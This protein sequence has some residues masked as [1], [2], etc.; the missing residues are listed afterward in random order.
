MKDGFNSRSSNLKDSQMKR[1]AIYFSIGGGLLIALVSFITAFGSLLFNS[2][3]YAESISSSLESYEAQAQKALESWIDLEENNKLLTADYQL[4][5]QEI[6]QKPFSLIIRSGINDSLLFYSG[7]SIFPFLFQYSRGEF[8]SKVVENSRGLFY[9]SGKALSSTRQGLLIIPLYRKYPIQN[10]FLKD[11]FELSSSI[12]SNLEIE[13]EPGLFPIYN[14][15]GEAIAYLKPGFYKADKTIQVIIFFI[16][17]AGIIFLLSGISSMLKTMSLTWHFTQVLGASVL[18]AFLTWFLFKISGTFTYFDF[19]SILQFNSDLAGKWTNS[20]LE[21]I[22]Q[23]ALVSWIGFMLLHFFYL[24]KFNIKVAS[25][26]LIVLLL[27]L[28]IA[29]FILLYTLIH[30]STWVWLIPL[31]VFRGAEL[32]WQTLFMYLALF[33][34]NTSIFGVTGSLVKIGSKN[35]V[36]PKSILTACF[37][38]LFLITILV[39][40]EIIEVDLYFTIIMSLVFT[41]F[42]QYT[43]GKGEF[44]LS[45]LVILLVI[46]SLLISILIQYHSNREEKSEITRFISHLDGVGEESLIEP[47]LAFKT[48]LE[49]DAF[50][51][52]LTGGV[53]MFSSRIRAE[54]RIKTI[55]ARD[56]NL[57]RNFKLEFEMFRADSISWNNPNNTIAKTLENIQLE[58][59]APLSSEIWSN[60]SFG[61]QEHISFFVKVATENRVNFIKIRLS[62][63]DI[64]ETRVYPLLL[65][66]TDGFQ[67]RI[68]LDY[69]VYQH[70]YKIQHLGLQWPFIFYPSGEE[71]DAGKANLDFFRPNLYQLKNGNILLLQKSENNWYHWFTQFLILFFF[72]LFLVLL[73]VL[74]N[75][76]YQIL[77]FDQLTNFR[78]LDSLRNKIYLALVAVTMVAFFVAGIV[79]IANFN[80]TSEKFIRN[81]LHNKLQG[82]ITE[83]KNHLIDHQSI[84][85]LNLGS[86]AGSYDVDVNLY[87]SSGR[88]VLSSQPEI[89]ANGINST[90]INRN[91]LNKL[92]TNRTEYVFRTEATGKLKY[93]NAYARLSQPDF[94][95]TYFISL[96]FYAQEHERTKDLQQ[97]LSMLINIYVLLVYAAIGL[98]LIIIRLAINP[99]Q[100]ISDQIQEFRL[101]KS[102]AK[103]QWESSDEI[104]NLV[105]QYNKLVDELEQSAKMLAD[106]ER[107]VAW[108]EMARQIAHEIKN[109]LTPMK[110]NLQYL[111]KLSEK[112]PQDALMHLE[113]IVRSV[114]EQIDN[115]SGIASSFSEFAQLP[116]IETEPKD[117][118]PILRDIIYFYKYEKGGEIRL[119]TS[120]T[121]LIARMDKSYFLRVMNNLLNNAYQSIPE[122][123]EPEINIRVEL[124]DDVVFIQVED[125][126][127]GISDDMKDKIFQPHFSTKSSGMGLGLA[128]S[129]KLIEHSGGNITFSSVENQGTTFTV[130]LPAV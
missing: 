24:R 96:P 126:G 51:Q 72:F 26:F 57:L 77:P 101:G 81:Q 56:F 40:G 43:I 70:G 60:Q 14:L 110:L 98:G 73:F 99:L 21:L 54:E 102:N 124:L 41:V 7:N 80:R 58:G 86:V 92:K 44:G 46:N 115:L 45:W 29:G 71:L 111:I 22:T 30:N 129:K 104:G 67:S 122:D 38:V 3:Y 112:E 2:S 74:L 88:V 83:V 31:D 16:A 6:D 120:Q 82:V 116:D 89:F 10:Q 125:N 39:L 5:I 90:Y 12:P 91:V 119:I 53:F 75:D 68:G 13:L 20:F 48:N 25:W 61:G 4:F 11:K 1:S 19:T 66:D 94:A 63:V 114:T 52:E 100:I 33:I 36:T 117:V 28:S 18:V 8:A 103:I 113:P 27:G 34:L 32:L 15:S 105:R 47:V 78:L 123:Q 64:P 59:Y 76:L 95:E 37:V 49:Q 23:I 69:A 109:P 62:R 42:L 128:I 35:N 84:E 17:L 130:T 55:F 87:N 50:L 79:S 97:Y 106:S 121:R 107:K 118:I 9:V 108:S 85:G 127:I 93:L 65:Q